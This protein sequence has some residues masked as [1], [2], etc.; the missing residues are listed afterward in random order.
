MR[1]HSDAWHNVVLHRPRIE[2]ERDGE[3]W[4]VILGSHGWLH[5]NREQALHE[6]AALERIEREGCA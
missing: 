3:A 1:L 5:G 4:L 2:R 6:F